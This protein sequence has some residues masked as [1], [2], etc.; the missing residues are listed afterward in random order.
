[1]RGVYAADCPCIGD[2]SCQKEGKHTFP[3]FKDHAVLGICVVERKPKTSEH[4]PVYSKDCN[5]KCSPPAETHMFVLHGCR[6]WPI[7]EGQDVLW[8]CVLLLR[9]FSHDVD[10]DE[11]TL[12]II[13]TLDSKRIKF[14]DALSFYFGKGRQAH[15]VPTDIF[16]GKVLERF[17]WIHG[18][19]YIMEMKRFSLAENSPW[20]LEARKQHST[21]G[22][23]F[24]CEG[25]TFCITFW[26]G[27]T[28]TEDHAN[29]IYSRTVK[30]EDHLH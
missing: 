16:R 28:A 10:N 6:L 14:A 9:Q 18:E 23:I 1:M 3:S 26:Y 8:K 24:F 11:D 30:L 22:F 13:P 12:K 17:F 27:A 15:F 2:P 19:T 4:A 5:L 21:A 29:M 7:F 25:C 20:A